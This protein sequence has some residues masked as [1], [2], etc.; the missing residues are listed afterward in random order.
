MSM[1]IGRLG[2][3]REIT[4]GAEMDRSP[5]LGVKEFRSLGGGVTTW[6][7]PTQPRRLSLSWDAMQPEDAYHVDRLARRVDGPGPVHVVDPGSD[8]WLTATQ[9]SGRVMLSTLDEWVHDPAVIFPP[10]SLDWDILRISMPV[11]GGSMRIQ[12][13]RPDGT[14][15]PVAPGMR[16]SFWVPG[17]VGVA[18]E[19]RYYFQ[20][21]TG[22]SVSSTG[23]GNT[24]VDRPFI[25][26]APEGAAYV[27]PVVWF[28]RTFVDLPM[29]G[30]VLREARPED[31][32][33][34]AVKRQAFSTAMQAGT[35]P[36]TDYTAGTGVTLSVS[37][38]K[39]MLASTGVA[40]SALSFGTATRFAVTP[41]EI[42][43]LTHA[44]PGATTTTLVWTD[45]A[46][47]V[48][49]QSR[50]TSIGRV[51]PGAAYVWPKVE[52]GAVATATAIGAASLEIT[53]APD[54]PPG[55]GM[56]P[57]SVTG[58]SQ[59]SAAGTADMRSVSL[60]LV[61]VAT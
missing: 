29:T 8:N 18:T 40:G 36:V 60:E 52:L 33:A 47:A 4:D 30:G 41:G 10:A 25:A 13:K 3:M 22:A 2:A 50:D 9:G 6:A 15:Y 43:T 21:A 35:G 26:T 56:R 1:W 39:A 28:G 57:Y 5:E 44:V 17:L 23:A 42:V 53:T 24:K 59:T 58:Y 11:S 12:Y 14:P 37:G 38:G 46:G 55:E 49:G 61:E 51:P 31:V 20:T 45:S 32:T 27:V 16:V 34:R 19:W 7:P 48:E 54:V